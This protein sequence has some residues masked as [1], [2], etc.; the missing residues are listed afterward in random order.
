M[1]E[2]PNVEQTFLSAPETEP[3]AFCATLPHS[4]SDLPVHKTRRRLPHWTCEAV[5]YWITFR[6]ADSLPQDKLNQWWEERRVWLRHNPLPWSD[7]QWRVYG[8]RFGD[9]LEGWLDAGHGSRALARGDVRAAVRDCLLRFEG[10][11]LRLHAAVIMSNHV[12]L[13]METLHGHNL[14]ELTKGMKG[15]SARKANQLLGIS[16]QFWLDESFDHI[17]RSEAQYDHYVRYI[18]ENPAKASLCEHEYWLYRCNAGIQASPSVESGG[19]IA[20]C[21]PAPAS[22]QTRMSAPR[23]TRPEK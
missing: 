2:K 6:L 18:V 15:A 22:G 16:G 12:H 13:L 4:I 7:Q 10:E 8:T 5:I 9:R 21:R 3:P 23:S 19:D 1:G 20:V 11:R 17:V 14:P